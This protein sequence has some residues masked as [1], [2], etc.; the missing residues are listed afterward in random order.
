MGADKYS[1]CPRCVLAADKRKA[2]A[3]DAAGEAY[4]K[5]PADE[6][7]E[8]IRE[9]S[10]TPT[11]KETVAQYIEATLS[12]DGYFSVSFSAGCRACGYKFEFKHSCQT[13]IGEPEPEP[14]KRKPR[15]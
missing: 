10:A 4:G 11:P 7:H 6:W 13:E 3:L 15:K 12:D 1:I 9:A 14:P 8:M 5:I 2:K